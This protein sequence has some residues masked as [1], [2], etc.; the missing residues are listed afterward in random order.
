MRK[1]V[2]DIE[3]KK[4]VKAAQKCIRRTRVDND[5]NLHKVLVCVV[6]DVEIT[7]TERV[8]HVSKEKLLKTR[9]Y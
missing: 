6:C 3:I 8:C 2:I 7:G 1:D 5:I 9:T 4:S